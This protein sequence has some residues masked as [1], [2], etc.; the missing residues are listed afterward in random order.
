MEELKEKLPLWNGQ[1]KPRSVFSDD[2]AWNGFRVASPLQWTFPE[3]GKNFL[4][5]MD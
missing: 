1:T 4:N 3:T 5:K 2:A